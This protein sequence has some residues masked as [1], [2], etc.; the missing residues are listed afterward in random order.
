M[1]KKIIDRCYTVCHDAG[2]NLLPPKAINTRNLILNNGTNGALLKQKSSGQCFISKETWQKKALSLS[3][4]TTTL[5]FL[6]TP[7]NQKNTQNFPVWN[8]AKT[9]LGLGL[10]LG[11]N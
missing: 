11:E 7:H 5:S 4:T 3:V 1:I 9:P 8:E 10:P 6:S 2:T